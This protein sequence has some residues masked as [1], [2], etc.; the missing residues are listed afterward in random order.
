MQVCTLLETH[1]RSEATFSIVIPNFQKILKSSRVLKSLAR[2]SR[3]VVYSKEMPQISCGNCQA[4]LETAYFKCMDCGEVVHCPNCDP[5]G[6]LDEDRA[7]SSGPFFRPLCPR[8]GFASRGRGF[9]DHSSHVSCPRGRFA[10]RGGHFDARP[11]SPYDRANFASAAP[12]PGAIRGCGFGPRGF[13]GVP[14]R[15]PF[16]KTFG[17]LAEDFSPMTMMIRCRGGFGPL[18]G[19][20]QGRAGLPPGVPEMGVA[21]GRAGC[22][23]RG[24]LGPFPGARGMGCGEC[25]HQNVFPEMVAGENSQVPSG[26]PCP[27]HDPRGKSCPGVDHDPKGEILPGGDDSDYQENIPDTRGELCAEPRAEPI[28]VDHEG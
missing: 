28:V 23:G 4:K 22:R 27:G 26:E 8:G 24:G 3:M 15:C 20:S 17:A 14:P 6:S 25:N 2:I 19:A 10:A 18:A 1:K 9:H 11:Q 16:P 12:F 13:G 5:R 7:P 21:R